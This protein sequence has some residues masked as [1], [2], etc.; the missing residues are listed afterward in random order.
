MRAAVNHHQNYSTPEKKPHPDAQTT[1]TCH[2]D[3][4]TPPLR[5]APFRDRILKKMIKPLWTYGCIDQ[6]LLARPLLYF[7]IIVFRVFSHA[8]ILTEKGPQKA[9][10]GQYVAQHREEKFVKSQPDPPS[11]YPGRV[12]KRYLG[13]RQRTLFFGFGHVSQM[14]SKICVLRNYL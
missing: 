14:F 4:I 3:P 6:L 7:A 10:W 1:V 9:P 2:G 5:E 11:D 13:L 8:Q 12:P